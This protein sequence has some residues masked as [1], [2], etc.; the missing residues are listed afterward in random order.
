MRSPGGRVDPFVHYSSFS[1]PFFFPLPPHRSLATTLNTR[2][3]HPTRRACV[4]A[5]P[6]AAPLHTMNGKPAANAPPAGGVSL[7]GGEFCVCAR[8]EGGG[9]GEKAGRG[10]PSFPCTTHPPRQ[11]ADRCRRSPRVGMGGCYR[12][13]APRSAPQSGVHWGAVG[14]GQP[15]RSSPA[16]GDR[17]KALARRHAAAHPLT[18]TLPSFDAHP[19]QAPS[20]RPTS[21]S[22]PSR[23]ATCRSC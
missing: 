19:P 8:R 20:P 1:H 10:R 21:C 23:P 13:P 4:R 17:S 5:P 6:A 16:L 9:E 3:P 15:P 2:P 7:P 14:R 11:A 22:G 18:T 12:R